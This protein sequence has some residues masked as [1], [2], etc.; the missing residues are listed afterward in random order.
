MS[1]LPTIV[2][3]IIAGLCTGLLVYIGYCAGRQ[4]AR[5]SNRSREQAI[6][7]AAYRDGCEWSADFWRKHMNQTE[8]NELYQGHYTKESS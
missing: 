3:C 2:Q 6:R 1:E 8:W 5:R 7:K 4:A